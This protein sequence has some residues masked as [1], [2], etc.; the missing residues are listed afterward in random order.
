MQ[1]SA[2]GKQPEGDQE[3]PQTN[4]IRTGFKCLNSG[5]TKILKPIHCLQWNAV[6][7]GQKSVGAELGRNFIIQFHP[8]TMEPGW[9]DSEPGGAAL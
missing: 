3:H 2:E 9:G 5:G 7:E 4:G 6:D 1:C 8:R